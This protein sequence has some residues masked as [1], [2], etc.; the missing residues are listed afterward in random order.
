MI[1]F[2]QLVGCLSEVER[3]SASAGCSSWRAPTLGLAGGHVFGGQ[4]IGQAIMISARLRPDMT[5]K[6]VSVVFPRGARDTGTLEYRAEELHT[7]SGYATTRIDLAQPGRDDGPRVGFSAHVMSHRPGAGVEHQVAMPAA[8]RPDDAR[9]ADLGLVPWPTRVVGDTDL[10]DRRTQPDELLLWMRMGDGV[11]ADGATPA[12][13]LAFASEL[14]LIGTALLPHDGWSQLDAHRALRTSVLAHSVQF[15]RPIR[16]DQ[17]LLLSHTGTV[18]TGGSA[19]GTG[20]VFAEDGTLVAGFQQ[21]SMI[22]LAEQ[23]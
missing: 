16:P 2:D 1:T 11:P 13:L 21:E 17:W 8:G 3:T 14:S 9:P 22:R 19:F 12:A 20:L 18:A 7:G 15:H 10:D 6:S 5:V 4:M 23:P